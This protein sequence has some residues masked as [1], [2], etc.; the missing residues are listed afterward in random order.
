MWI[1]Y[2]TIA[3]VCLIATSVYARTPTT[4]S[5]TTAHTPVTS[6]EEIT[7]DTGKMG[8]EGCLGRLM[9]QIQSSHTTRNFLVVPKRGRW[10]SF[11]R[12]YPGLTI[13]SDAS[14]GR[15]VPVIVVSDLKQAEMVKNSFSL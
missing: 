15:G 4:R 12:R 10:R 1:K 11:E 6:I 9:L 8:Q 7:P 3:V 14:A 2:L 13:Q 5:S